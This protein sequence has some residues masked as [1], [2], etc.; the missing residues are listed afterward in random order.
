M[1]IV[2]RSAIILLI[3]I[4]N[5]QFTGCKKCVQN[6]R[7]DLQFTQDELKIDPYTGNE[8][9]T[10]IGSSGD[11]VLIHNGSRFTSHIRVY[12]YDFE[13]AKLDHDGCQGDYFEVDNHQMMMYDDTLKTFLYIFLNFKYS[14][15]NPSDEMFF[16][17]LFGQSKDLFIFFDGRFKFNVDTL[18]N[19]QTNNQYYKDSIIAFHPIWESGSNI[20]YNVYELY[21][22]QPDTRYTPWISIAYYSIKE[23]LLG[24]KTTNG[25]TWHIQKE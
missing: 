10:F 3:L 2:M 19:I 5:V 22:H 9:L 1:Q 11:T 14:W 16:E 23:G 6:Q 21:G 25:A 7:A 8:I 15:T 18:L 13:T 24:F 20:F 4:I 12:Q 17:L